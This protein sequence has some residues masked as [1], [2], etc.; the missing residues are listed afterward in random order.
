MTRHQPGMTTS[1]RPPATTAAVVVWR[2]ERLR[3]AGFPP[4]LARSLARD[5]GMDLHALIKLVERGCPA[6]L[7]AR[8]LGPLPEE[9]RPC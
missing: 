8:I 1:T 7:A 2:A 9:H 6:Q 3:R 5:C 4:E